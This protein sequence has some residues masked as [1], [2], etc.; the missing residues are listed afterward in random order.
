MEQRYTALAEGHGKVAAQCKGLQRENEAVREVRV[1][2]RLLCP[3]P[4]P[5]FA[6]LPKAE[7]QHHSTCLVASGPS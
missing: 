1:C 3:L 5:P 6:A 4:P 7:V 2:A